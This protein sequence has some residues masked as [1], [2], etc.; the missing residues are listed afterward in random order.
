M[1]HKKNMQGPQGKI[2]GS[3]RKKYGGGVAI[4]KYSIWEAGPCNIIFS[5]PQD[6]K[7]KSP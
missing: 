4:N 6:L 3:Q 5:I 7:W 2:Q 1:G